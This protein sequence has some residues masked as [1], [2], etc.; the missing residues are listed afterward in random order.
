MQTSKDLYKQQ[1][2]NILALYDRTISVIENWRP[3]QAT[4][5]LDSDTSIYEYLK[6]L[7]NN[8]ESGKLLVVICGEYKQGK[9]SLLN[10]FLDEHDLFPVDVDISTNTIS[11]ITYG[12]EEKITVVFAKQSGKDEIRRVIT[13]NEIPN[14]VTEKGNPNNKH[15]VKTLIIESPNPKLKDGL[16]LID[17]PGIG[18]KNIEH[19]AI[20]YAILP[21]TDV[22]LYVSESP[23]STKDLNFIKE[24]LSVHCKN[25][26]FVVT[27]IDAKPDY[28]QLLDDNRKKIANT[29]SK[30]PSSVLIIPVSSRSKLR[31]LEK[32]SEKS[33]E[34]SNFPELEQVIWNLATQE[35]KGKTVVLQALYKLEGV[36]QLIRTPLFIEWKSYQQNSQEEMLQWQKKL[37]AATKK[38][39][40][41][42]DQNSSWKT[43][44]YRGIEDVGKQTKKWSQEK[45]I[46]LEDMAKNYINDPTRAENPTMIAQQVASDINVMYTD[47]ILEIEHEFTHLHRKL[48]ALTELSFNQSSISNRN[49]SSVELP[50][51]IG[52]SQQDSLNAVKSKFDDIVSVGRSISIN[53]IGGG[54]IGGIGG[55]VVGALLSIPLTGGTGI[56]PMAITGF[57]AGGY[58]GAGVGSIKGGIDGLEK[59]NDIKTAESKKNAQDIIIP[60]IQAY[61]LKFSTEIDDVLTAMKRSIED[62]F[63]AQIKRENSILRDGLDALKSAKEK[64]LI[65]QAERSKQLEAPLN[66]LNDIQSRIN[67]LGRVAQAVN[68]DL[69]TANTSNVRNYSRAEAMPTGMFT[70]ENLKASASIDKIH[71]DMGTW[72]DE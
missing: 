2:N 59:I 42:L 49:L 70:N 52:V 36:I 38:R 10:A 14:Y 51:T 55:A 26:I 25:L 13:R 24:K 37:E 69:A 22:A 17:T 20:T 32:G 31:Y 46:L 66:E 18:S 9:S 54:T 65:Q 16:V 6:K 19:T 47:L 30:D 43:E 33:L 15:Q 23:L 1:K 60:F 44:L 21:Y 12:V 5:E 61:K 68:F 50:K 45:L 3:S 28:H 71:V 58:I 40:N 34:N 41:F 72:A 62:E 57:H 39:E 63:I 67:D 8:F 11:T 64:T 53:S 29:L 7:R 56:I 27:K 48:E 35:G 4:L